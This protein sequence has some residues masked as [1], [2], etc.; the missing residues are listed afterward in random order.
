MKLTSAWK[1]LFFAWLPAAVWLAVIAFESTAYFG[2][3]NTARWTRRLLLLFN[4]HVTWNQVFYANY[5]LRKTGHFVGY[6]ILSWFFF[7]GWMETLAW[8]TESFLRRVRKPIVLPRR[9]H[10]RAAALAVLCTIVV[11]SLDEFHQAFIP[12][13]TGLFHDVVL[14]TFG[15]IFAQ[16]LLLIHWTSKKELIEPISR[17]SQVK[18]LPAAD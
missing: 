5:Y 14:D 6:G 2:G 9:W 10:L 3:S 4:D 18:E 11:A 15:G 1:R 8:Q 17:P 13:R 12:G 7:R 16:L